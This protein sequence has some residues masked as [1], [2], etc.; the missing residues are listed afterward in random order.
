M[1]EARNHWCISRQR[2]WGLP[3]P[4]FY[5]NDCGH[6]HLTGESVERVARVVEREGSSSWWQDEHDASLLH[7]RDKHRCTQCGG[8]SFRKET[9]TVDVWL[10]SGC[11]PFAVIAN[12]PEL[13]D[14]PFE[15]VL[16]GSDQHRG[17]FQAL[18]LIYVALYGRAPFKTVVT[19]GFVVDEHGKKQS[20]S[21]GNVVYP[22]TVI[23][24]YGADVLRLWVALG[25][26]PSGPRSAATIWLSTQAEDYRKLRNTMR[27][28]LGPTCTTS[29]P[30]GI[31]S[32][33]ASCPLDA[34]ILHR[35]NELVQDVTA[36]YDR[37]EFQRVSQLL[38]N[39][40]Q[41]G[42]VQSLF[43][44]RLQRHPLLA[45]TE[46]AQ[47]PGGA[48][49]CSSTFL[50]TLVRLMAPIVPHL[51]RK[52]SG[53]TCRRRSGWQER[54]RWSVLLAS[55]PTGTRKSSATTKL[56]Q[57]YS[58]LVKVRSV[59]NKALELARNAKKIGKTQDGS[60]VLSFTD[61]E[62]LAK[63]NALDNAELT[64]LLMTSQATVMAERSNA[65]GVSQEAPPATSVTPHAYEQSQVL[66]EHANHGVHVSWYC[67]RWERSASCCWN[68][69]SN[70]GD[71]TSHPDLCLKCVEVV[72]EE[73]A[74]A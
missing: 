14:C 49:S 74:P 60:V 41:R 5:C 36:S 19:H 30:P 68:F 73:K 59:S 29:I 28:P 22:D 45:W 17:W 3:I 13:G 64:S 37:Y 72:G 33:S 69:R 1:V 58:G 71:H 67:R 44:R 52:T 53:S 34:F 35:L 56:A 32:D 48:D 50:Q 70:V 51:G 47:P 7:G 38:L 18:L 66:A 63:V 24:K 31:A 65:D 25:R 21:D 54:A 42:A 10:D 4:A 40:W 16:E 27:F 39:F 12:R 23:K 46:V 43:L 11:S 62:L 57:L 2:P 20:K 9:D 26:L 8:A 61:D 55:F 6:H 15:M